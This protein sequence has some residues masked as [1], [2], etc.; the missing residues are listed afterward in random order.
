MTFVLSPSAISATKSKEIKI[1]AAEGYDLY[2]QVDLLVPKK[3]KIFINNSRSYSFIPREFISNKY[4]K[5]AK[6]LNLVIYPD[7]IIKKNN[8]THILSKNE[9]FKSNCIFENFKHKISTTR[10]SRNPFN[11]RSKVTFYIHEVN[12][13]KC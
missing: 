6:S 7:D 10:S 8:I 1:I 9:K 4:F 12:N 2:Q 5:T 11:L 13:D 3:S